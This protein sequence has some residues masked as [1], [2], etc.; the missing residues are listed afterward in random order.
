M[1]KKNTGERRQG[2]RSKIQIWAEEKR[3]N[4]VYYHL[5][6][7]LSKTGLFIEKKLP[8]PVGSTVKLELKLPESDEKIIVKGNIIGNYQDPSLKNM[9]A[10]LKFVDMDQEVIEKIDRFLNK[11]EL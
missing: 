7:N 10:G 2:Q 4:S 5:L 9:G 6:T 1:G 3:E 11:Y 8:F